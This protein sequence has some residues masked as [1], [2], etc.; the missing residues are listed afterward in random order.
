MSTHH[1]TLHS[2]V[3]GVCRDLHNNDITTISSGTF[4]GL[5]RLTLLC[6]HPWC[7]ENGVVGKWC[8]VSVIIYEFVCFLCFG[9]FI[10]VCD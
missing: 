10:Y 3:C 6:A 7:G 5:G 2:A 4:E 8:D 1:T 9:A